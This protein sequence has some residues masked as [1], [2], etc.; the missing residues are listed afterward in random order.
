MLTQNK[1]FKKVEA[2]SIVDEYLEH[3]RVMVFNHGGNEKAF[4][5]LK[6]NDKDFLLNNFIPVPA[7]LMEAYA[8]SPAKNPASIGQA[9]I[10]AF[11]KLFTP[12]LPTPTAH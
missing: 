1:Q 7:L 3:A 9:F 12:K 11:H 10:E 5:A 6:A 4:I 2:I 8:N